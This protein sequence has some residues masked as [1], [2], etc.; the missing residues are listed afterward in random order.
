MAFVGKCWVGMSRQLNFTSHWVLLPD[1]RPWLP[2]FDGSWARSWRSH[3]ISAV[4][5]DSSQANPMLLRSPLGGC[6]AM[7]H[8]PPHLPTTYEATLP[9]SEPPQPRLVSWHSFLPARLASIPSA[10][11]HCLVQ[12]ARECS[13]RL[14]PAASLNRRRLPC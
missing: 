9:T 14:A 4:E 13:V 8:T 5:L 12:R 7:V 3:L 6:S 10:A 2:S 11:D 1:N